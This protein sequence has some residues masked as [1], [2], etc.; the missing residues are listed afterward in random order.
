LAF[1]GVTKQTPTLA[2]VTTRRAWLVNVRV[3]Q[4]LVVVVS[5]GSLAGSARVTYVYRYG[6]KPVAI[7]VHVQ[8]PPYVLTGTVRP[9]KIV[10][11]PCVS[12]TIFTKNARKPPV[13]A[14][15]ASCDWGFNQTWRLYNTDCK[16]SLASR[17]TCFYVLSTGKNW[18]NRKAHVRCF[19][20]ADHMQRLAEVLAWQ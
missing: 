15:T 19:Y 18:P 8:Q 14:R 6:Q 3:L 2:S 20:P 13:E 1:S 5:Y 16:A 11:H 7:V 9:I 12:H 10:R 4:I 17:R